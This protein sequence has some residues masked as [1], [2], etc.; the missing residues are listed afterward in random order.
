MREKYCLMV[1]HVDRQC[2][3]LLGPKP[4]IGGKDY[5]RGMRQ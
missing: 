2:I 5:N 1:F 3:I 4:L